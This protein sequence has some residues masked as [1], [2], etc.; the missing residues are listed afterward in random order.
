M[1]IPRT[2]KCVKGCGLLSFARK[3]N[4]G[5]RTRLYKNGFQKSVHND[6]KFLGY[7]IENAVA[8]STDDKVVR[9]DENTRNVHEII[10]LQEKREEILL[11]QKCKTTKYRNY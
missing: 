7:K 11:L 5:Y 9:L 2:R 4:I 6:G 8:K 1:T 3:K 10:I